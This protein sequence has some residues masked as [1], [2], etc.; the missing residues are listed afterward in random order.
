MEKLL[1]VNKTLQ[2]IRRGLDRNPGKGNFK[3]VCFHPTCDVCKR[4]VEMLFDLL[5]LFGLFKVRQLLV[6]L[7]DKLEI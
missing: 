7:R 6:D 2:S 3:I 1:R 4:V 5:G